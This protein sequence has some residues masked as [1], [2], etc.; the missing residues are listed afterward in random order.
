MPAIKNNTGRAV[1]P[2]DLL[3]GPVPEPRRFIA[4]AHYS[5]SGA[6][7]ESNPERPQ[8]APFTSRAVAGIF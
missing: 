8:A 4:E 1:T 6:V 3:G 2:T 7:H 5:A